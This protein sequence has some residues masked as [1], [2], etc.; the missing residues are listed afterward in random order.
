MFYYV[1]QFVSICLYRFVV[2]VSFVRG[3]KKIVIL[4]SF[5]PFWKRE[6]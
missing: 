2:C 6:L 5:Q 4:I 1:S 3:E